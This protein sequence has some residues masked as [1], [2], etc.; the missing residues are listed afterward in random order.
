MPELVEVQP[1]ID[2]IALT[3]QSGFITNEKNGN[4]LLII[5]KPETAKTTSIFQFS[6]LDFV[7]YYDEITQKKLLDEFLPLVKVEQKKTLLIPDLVNC[8][9]KQK[10]TR[11]QFLNM[12]K[13][14][15]DDTGIVQISTY[16]KQLHYS[17]LVEG[18]K[19]NMITGTTAANYRQLEQEIRDTGLLSRYVPLSFDIPMDKVMKIFSCIE[20]G[21]I[22]DGIA[23]I[24]IPEIVQK[25]TEVQN[26]GILFKNFEMISQKLG[27][28]YEGF[29]FRAQTSLQRLA[30][31]NAMLE[32]R[33]TV[34]LKD[35][36]KIVYLSRWINYEYN[37]I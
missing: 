13:S 3:L 16:H 10:S 34:S 18:L 11:E 6:N 24:I 5:S 32:G 31:S 33:D 2:I 29:G 21:T 4:S 27:F 23:K 22:V 9:Q 14:G 7:S 12:I 17:K 36:D 37:M 8:I 15:I 20:T 30:K 1:L 25:K 19:F 28:K 26:D 35:I